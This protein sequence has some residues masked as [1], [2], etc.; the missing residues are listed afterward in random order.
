[1]CVPCQ[2]AGLPAWMD[3]GDDGM[4]GGGDRVWDVRVLVQGVGRKKEEF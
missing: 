1:M 4:D 2:P 3:R